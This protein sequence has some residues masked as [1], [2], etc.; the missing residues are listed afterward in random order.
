MKKVDFTEVVIGA[1]DAADDVVSMQK[2]LEAV[3]GWMY[4][5]DPE[6]RRVTA[7]QVVETVNSAS[8]S[9]SLTVACLEN[10]YRR[11]V[12]TGEPS[13][14]QRIDGNKLST[15]PVNRVHQIRP[16]FNF[17]VPLDMTE[18]EVARVQAFVYK[19]AMEFEAVRVR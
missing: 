5:L 4:A 12:L 2:F 6:A 15:E 7:G 17:V 1:M 9:E 18:L 8:H 13:I 10:A 14:V 19:T 3:C 16:G 11:A